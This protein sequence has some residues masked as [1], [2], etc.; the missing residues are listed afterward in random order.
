MELTISDFMRQA[1]ESLSGRWG[2]VIGALAIYILVAL[3]L[4]LFGMIPCIGIPIVIAVSGSLMLGISAFYLAIARNEEAEMVMFLEGFRNLLRSV[5]LYILYAIAVTIGLALLI[6][7]GVL[8]MLYLAFIWFILADEPKS[9]IIDVMI[10]SAAMTDGYKMKLFIL[11]LIF[12]GLT[13]LSALTLFIGL[14]WVIPFIYTTWAKIYE[15]A[16]ANYKQKQ[17][18]LIAE[19]QK[20]FSW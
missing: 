15:D 12:L 3:P 17:S 16:K 5:G 8:L 7:P 10:K 18:A 20:R 4:A 6:I 1:R 9:D 11:Y 19:E 14:F 13:I 2:L